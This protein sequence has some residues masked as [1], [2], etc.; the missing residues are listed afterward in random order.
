MPALS[1]EAEK[2][3][4][5]E[6]FGLALR[7]EHEQRAVGPQAKVHARIAG[8]VQRTE[9]ALRQ[10]LQAARRCPPAD[11]SAAAVVMP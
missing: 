2:S 10:L 5:A 7:L 1:A 9:N 11:S 6:I 3:S 4:A 8:Q